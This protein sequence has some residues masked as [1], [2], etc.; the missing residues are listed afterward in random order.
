MYFFL[1]TVVSMTG[2][3]PVTCGFGGRRAIQLRHIE[4]EPTGRF[5]LPT[6]RLPHGCSH[7]LSYIGLFRDHSGPRGASSGIRTHITRF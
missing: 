4:R 3:E 1:L 2:V 6:F 5:E 7:H